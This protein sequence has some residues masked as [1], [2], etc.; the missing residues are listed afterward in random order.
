MADKATMAPPSYEHQMQASGVII[1]PLHDELPASLQAGRLSSIGEKNNG[2]DVAGF[3]LMSLPRYAYI[4]VAVADVCALSTC[5]VL[6]GGQGSSG[7]RRIWRTAQH[8]LQSA[9]LPADAGRHAGSR[10]ACSTGRNDGASRPE[11]AALLPT[12]AGWADFP[13]GHRGA[14][15]H[16]HPLRRLWLPGLVAHHVRL[17]LPC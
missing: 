11:Q 6:R 9:Q 8:V 2:G 16:P 17:P 15:P 5:R 1:T 14:S 12:R 13:R 7:A 4:A 10:S 3:Y